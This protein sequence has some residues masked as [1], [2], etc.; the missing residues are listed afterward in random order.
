[1]CLVLTLHKNV[2][3]AF[4]GKSRYGF[5]AV[6]TFFIIFEKLKISYSPLQPTF[7]IM[8]LIADAG[9]T[10]T[11]WGL[12][13][14]PTRTRSTFTTSGINAA[15]MDAADIAGVVTAELLP[16]LGGL[17]VT[18]VHFYGAGIVSSERARIIT[19]ALRPLQ[20]DIVSVSTD[21][22]GA[23]RA[24]FG[25]NA[26]IAAIIG[27]GSATCLYD[28]N[29]I[30]DNIPSLGYILGDEGSGASIGRRFT[31][32]LFKRCLPD[33]VAEAWQREIALSAADVIE[34]V[35]RSPRPN[36]FLASLMPFIVSQAVCPEVA[37][38]ID[39]EFDRF[40]RR[41]VIPYRTASRSIGF[42][43]SL[44]AA[45]SDRLS[46]AAS[47]HGYEITAVISSPLASLMS[48]HSEKN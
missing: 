45:L 24:I 2:I 19:E 32:D 28:G 38:I 46:R 34:R 9:G 40:F 6:P 47:R 44:A 22:L 17:P 13:D 7:P 18:A 8:I 43:G 33:S 30:T 26:G 1:M 25:H 5:N 4:T 42:V 12:I 41:C 35:Y 11:A 10:K 29:R 20:A 15:T 21:I 31:S 14:S 16:A 3:H 23:A 36:A 37:A 48:Y 39:D 27:T